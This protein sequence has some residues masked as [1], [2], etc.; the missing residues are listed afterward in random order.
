MLQV[1]N[2]HLVASISLDTA[3][4][5][6]PLPP[7]PANLL[8]SHSC[9][10]PQLIML[11]NVDNLGKK[12]SKQ[13]T[14]RTML[15]MTGKWTLLDLSKLSDV[16]YV[17]RSNLEKT[18]EWITTGTQCKRHRDWFLEAIYTFW[19]WLH[20]LCQTWLWICNTFRENWLHKDWITP[21]VTNHLLS[22]H[23]HLILLTA[24]CGRKM[25]K[26]NHKSPHLL[27][28]NNLQ[29]TVPLLSS[30]MPGEILQSPR[31]DPRQTQLLKKIGNVKST[32]HAKILQI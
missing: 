16:V 10:W 14:A 12:S 21:L 25:R 6:F 23:H 20:H 30:H 13:G 11:Y 9:Y 19:I 28:S 17:A 7:A 8:Y 3:C 24:F 32:T 1:E 27:W 31:G 4:F 22:I 15:R 26:A 5:S 18:G 2:T 29:K